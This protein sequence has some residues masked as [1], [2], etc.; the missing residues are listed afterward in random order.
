MMDPPADPS[1]KDTL[2]GDDKNT[3][4]CGQCEE[5]FVIEAG[6]YR[7]QD[8]CHKCS[9]RSRS[10]I[11]SAG[12]DK[13]VIEWFRGLRKTDPEQYKK[14]LADADAKI[15]GSSSS[16][17]ETGS[18]LGK[19]NFNLAR[20][21]E[22]S[23]L[24]LFLRWDAVRMSSVTSVYHSQIIWISWACLF[25][26]AA[27]V[28]WFHHG[29]SN[30]HHRPTKRHAANVCLVAGSCSPFRGTR[31]PGGPAFSGNSGWL[32]F[33]DPEY[34]NRNSW[35]RPSK[36]MKGVVGILLYKWP[37]P[38]LNLWLRWMRWMQRI[39][40]KDWSWNHGLLR[41]FRRRLILLIMIISNSGMC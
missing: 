33:L 32:S 22:V 10:V 9:S 17:G 1:G 25:D 4:V 26:G 13:N 39:Y 30:T 37:G 36:S 11:N 28:E 14:I 16:G 23:W 34:I 40:Q 35:Q 29:T 41:I 18:K 19:D 31:T 6:K 7:L 24:S 21:K 5:K 38:Y 20:Y 12:G 27:R 2:A 3:L 8:H 15:K